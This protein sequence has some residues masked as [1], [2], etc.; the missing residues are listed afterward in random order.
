MDGCVVIFVGQEASGMPRQVFWW[1]LP[2]EPLGVKG[3]C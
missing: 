1:K 3:I 2:L